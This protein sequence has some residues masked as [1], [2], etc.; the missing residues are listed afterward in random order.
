MALRL[1]SYSGPGKAFPPLQ[2][3]FVY[4]ILRVR[5]ISRY[6]HMWHFLCHLIINSGECTAYLVH[7]EKYG[8]MNVVMLSLVCVNLL[9]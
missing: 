1:M 2:F 3:T 6:A 5:V 4:N 9:K 7:W 8:H